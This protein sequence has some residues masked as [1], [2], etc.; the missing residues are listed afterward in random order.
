MNIHD[1]INRIFKEA[2]DEL[3]RKAAEKRDREER[4]LMADNVI[5]EGGFHE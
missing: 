4:T 1:E 5:T 3:W 2:T